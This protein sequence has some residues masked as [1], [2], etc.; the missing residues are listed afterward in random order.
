MEQKWFYDLGG[1]IQNSR[2]EMRQNLTKNFAIFQRI[3]SIYFQ[4][5]DGKML[6]TKLFHEDDISG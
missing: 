4:T 5:G 3:T 6:N 1:S 2:D